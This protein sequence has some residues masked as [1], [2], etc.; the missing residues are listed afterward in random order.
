M[1]VL[2][3]HPPLSANREV[4]PPLGLCTLSAW[5][6]QQGHHVRLLDLDLAVKGRTDGEEAYSGCFS[7]VEGFLAYKR[8]A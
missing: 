2:L 1:R 3:V 6:R 8:S 4:T 5:L 7:R